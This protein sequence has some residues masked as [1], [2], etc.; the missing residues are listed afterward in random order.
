M[1]FTRRDDNLANPLTV[2]YT[3]GGTATNGVDYEKLTGS[4]VIPAGQSE[5]KLRVRPIAVN[6]A[7]PAKEI[8]LKLLAAPN[9]YD[10]GKQVRAHVKLIDSATQ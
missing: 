2:H 3:T 10:L 8:V 6:G 5:V 1:I 9:A 7:V 4:V